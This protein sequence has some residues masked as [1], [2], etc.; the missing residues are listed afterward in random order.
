L[1]ASGITWYHLYVVAPEEEAVDVLALWPLRLP[2]GQGPVLFESLD[3]D[4]V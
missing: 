4:G 1:A 3:S 2:A